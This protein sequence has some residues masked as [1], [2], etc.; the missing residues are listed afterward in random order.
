MKVTHRYYVLMI[1]D[2]FILVYKYI[3]IYIYIKSYFL[4]IKSI[5]LFVNY[6][7]FKNTTLNIYISLIYIYI[8]MYS[9]Y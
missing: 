9:I 6:N 3:Y 5:Y 8:M 2:S 4:Y 1:V 7:V